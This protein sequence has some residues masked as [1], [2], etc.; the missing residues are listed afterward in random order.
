MWRNCCGQCWWRWVV[1]TPRSCY[2]RSLRKCKLD[3]MECV[4]WSETS[5]AL[6]IYVRG[7]SFH[8]WK[9]SL[10]SL[11]IQEHFNAE[12]LCFMSTL[13][14]SPS[15]KLLHNVSYFVFA[16]LFPHRKVFC[17]YL[18]PQ[19]QNLQLMSCY[20]SF[21]WQLSHASKVL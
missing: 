14:K 7:I 4:N 18:V 6:W 19:G 20:L 8:S 5:K 11:C 15:V 13:F 16:R 17:I 10:Y 12:I 3:R 9:F 21:Q 1:V 2:T